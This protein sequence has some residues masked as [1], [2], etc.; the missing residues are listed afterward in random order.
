MSFSGAGAGGHRDDPLLCLRA[1]SRP[2]WLSGTEQAGAGIQRH[3]AAGAGGPATCGLQ[4]L[5]D[6]S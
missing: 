2:R 4:V 5:F 1:G 3:A 6:W